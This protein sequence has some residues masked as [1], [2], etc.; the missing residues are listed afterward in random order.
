MCIFKSCRRFLEVNNKTRFKAKVN[1]IMTMGLL[2][3]LERLFEP[4][5]RRCLL[6]ADICSEVLTHCDGNAPDRGEHGGELKGL[7]FPQRDALHR[8]TGEVAGFSPSMLNCGC[9]C[10][11]VCRRWVCDWRRCWEEVNSGRLS[12]GP[13][14]SSHLNLWAYHCDNLRLLSFILSFNCDSACPLLRLND[15]MAT[16]DLII[17]CVWIERVML[18]AVGGRC[19][20]LMTPCDCCACSASIVFIVIGL[21]WF[22]FCRSGQMRLALESKASRWRQGF[23]TR[24]AL[25]PAQPGQVTAS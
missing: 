8:S 6:T 11:L 10:V 9:V 23:Q 24:D 19:P 20:E 22:V 25:Q 1:V 3:F 5:R 21:G 15:L 17:D 2:C 13:A 16:D 14:S 12:K 7:G 4:C 18:P